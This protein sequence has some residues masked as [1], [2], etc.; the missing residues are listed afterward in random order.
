MAGRGVGSLPGGSGREQAV[1]EQQELGRRVPGA[2]MPERDQ[3]VLQES[4]HPVACS[5]RVT[6]WPGW[7]GSGSAR[8]AAR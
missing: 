2:R 5:A 6:A 3:L 8:S 4:P 7:A 1:D